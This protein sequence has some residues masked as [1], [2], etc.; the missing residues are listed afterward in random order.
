M[1]IRAQPAFGFNLSQRI[2]LIERNF[3]E[4]EQDNV[5]CL[6]N[7]VINSEIEDSF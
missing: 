1:G 5:S 2:S 6:I 7:A 3:I 4:V